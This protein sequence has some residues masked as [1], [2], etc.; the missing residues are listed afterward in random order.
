MHLI[1]T[2]LFFAHS[3]LSPSILPDAVISVSQLL[4][5]LPVALAK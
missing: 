4:L 5:L 1:H 2:Q 3:H